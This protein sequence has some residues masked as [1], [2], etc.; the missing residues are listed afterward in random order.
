MY[1]V[2]S[3]PLVYHELFVP[4]QRDPQCLLQNL[5]DIG[6]FS[7]YILYQSEHDIRIA[8]SALCSISVSSEAVLF[9]CMGQKQSQPISDPLK[10]VE[11][12]LA[13]L[14]IEDWTAY[15]YIGFDVARFYSPYSKAIQQ[16]LLHFLVPETELHIT[17]KG[18]RIRS[19]KS[20]SKILEALSIDRPLRNYTATPQP[21]IL[22]IENTIKL[23]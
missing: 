5:L 13:S 9:N 22:P 16:P 3:N 21:L 17:A 8:G 10:Q 19:V 14:P 2:A 12:A 11:S 4:I 1:H 18:I 15:G 23:R 7:S 20:L 6:L